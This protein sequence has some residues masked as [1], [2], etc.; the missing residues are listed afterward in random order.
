MIQLRDDQLTDSELANR[1]LALVSQTTKRRDLSRPPL[2]I[3]NN[4]PDIAAATQADGVHLGQDDLTVKAARTPARPPQ[5]N[6][7]FDALDRTSPRRRTRRS[8]L[9]RCWPDFS[10]DYQNVR[11]VSLDSNTCGKSLPKSAC[12]LLR[13]GG[14]QAET[15]RRCLGLRLLV[16][17]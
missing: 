17:R 10:I 11:R 16:W 8:E 6:R 9:P 13:S 2:T 15:C 4:R 1:A 14:I 12:Q 3:I 5:T 7:H